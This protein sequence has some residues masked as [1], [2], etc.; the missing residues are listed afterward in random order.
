MRSLSKAY[1]LTCVQNMNTL[2][3]I[4]DPLKLFVRI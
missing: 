2:E 4:N 3:K 1:H